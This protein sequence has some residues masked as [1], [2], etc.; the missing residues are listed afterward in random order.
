MSVIVVMVCK[1]LEVRI[2]SWKKKLS[3]YEDKES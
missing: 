1:K 3:D 2:F